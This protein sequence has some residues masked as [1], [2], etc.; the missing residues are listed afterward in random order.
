MTMMAERAYTSGRLEPRPQT[1]PDVPCEVTFWGERQYPGEAGRPG[2]TAECLPCSWRVHLEGG[3]DADDL[4]ELER[5]HT[6]G[7]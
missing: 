6:E 7:E 3:H 5:Q 1:H 2:L 4:A